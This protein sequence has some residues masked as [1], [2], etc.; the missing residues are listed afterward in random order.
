MMTVEQRKAI[1]RIYDRND[2]STADITYLQFR[3]TAVPSFGTDPCVM[4]PW[5][6]MWLGIE[7]DGYVHS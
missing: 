5:A 1:K 2:A 7:I 4:I 6:G 3:R